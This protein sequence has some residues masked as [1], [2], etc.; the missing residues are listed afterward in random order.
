MNRNK[1]LLVRIIDTVLSSFGRKG[2]AK[3]SNDPVLELKSRLSCHF[4]CY[5]KN[6]LGVEYQ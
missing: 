6:A 3:S 5:G 1:R 4:T 2:G